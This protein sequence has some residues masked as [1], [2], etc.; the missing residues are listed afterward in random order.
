MKILRLGPNYEAEELTRYL[1]DNLHVQN[2]DKDLLQ[3]C[4]IYDQ[5]P[6]S[7]ENMA[8]NYQGPLSY[9]SNQQGITRDPNTENSDLVIPCYK[10]VALEIRVTQKTRLIQRRHEAS[11]TEDPAS[12]ESPWGTSSKT[13]IVIKAESRLHLSHYYFCILSISCNPLSC[14]H[15]ITKLINKIFSENSRIIIM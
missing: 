6:P 14:K 5:M 2:T 9:T 12:W 7:F 10:E 3:A 15:C 4:H 13:R 11:L 1:Q 8:A